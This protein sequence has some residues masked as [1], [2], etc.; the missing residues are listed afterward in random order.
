[1]CPSGCIVL[2][3][4]RFYRSPVPGSCL[5]V[6]PTTSK[7]N[8]Q[9]L[10][11]NSQYNVYAAE[12]MALDIAITMW[13]DR[14]KEYPKCYFFTDSKA[15]GTSISQPQRQSGQSIIHSTINQFD[16]IMSRHTRQQLKLEIIW[17]LGHHKI[18]GNE[19]VDGEAKY[20]AINPC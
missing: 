8:H 13:Q 12:M 5:P 6:T 11:S 19:Q 18:A 4:N 20:A 10:S 14:V 1:M 16:N 2:S 17:I 7:A 9:H 15:A 3:L